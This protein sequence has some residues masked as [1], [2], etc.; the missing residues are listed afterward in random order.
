MIAKPIPSACYFT[1]SGTSSLHFRLNQKAMV[2]TMRDR[3]KNRKPLQRGRN[4]SIEAIQAVQT[5]KRANRNTHNDSSSELERVFDSKF[6]RL[7][8]FDMMAVL[9]ELLRQN[10]CFL[11][12]KVFNDIRKE[13]W[14]KPQVLLYADMIAVFAS[15][16]LIKEAELVYSNL[17]AE[18]NLDPNIEGFNAL[19]NALI[20][21]KLTQ[22]VMDC[23]EFMKALGGEPDRS[24][25]RILIN[26]LES[27]GET[28]SSA[29][30]RLDAQKYYGESLE[31]LE[32]EAEI[33]QLASNLSKW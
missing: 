18:S 28:S 11:A 26:G 20:S 24:S 29:I 31:F 33:I 6:R 12:M 7:L 16:G 1:I 2:I 9:R 14:Y 21:F 3:S 23:Y 25:F 17:K 8:K 30:L 4:L 27:L 13:V 5:L 32:E 15:N 19:F 22:L 10:E